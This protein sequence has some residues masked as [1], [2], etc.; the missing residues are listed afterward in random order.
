MEK[1]I[2]F[3]RDHSK[4]SKQAE[5]ILQDNAIEYAQLFLK[6]EEGCL[7]CLL[8]PDVAYKGIENIKGFVQSKK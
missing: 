5:K 3:L 4:E 1:E 2:I 6:P 8:T 7:P